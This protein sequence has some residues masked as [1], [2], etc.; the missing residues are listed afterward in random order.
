MDPAIAT[1]TPRTRLH[2]LTPS[3]TFAEMIRPHAS[4]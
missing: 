1:G 2:R 4:R 3:D